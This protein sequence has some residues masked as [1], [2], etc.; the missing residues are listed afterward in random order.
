MVCNESP[1]FQ[2]A[3]SHALQR[4]A[5]PSIQGSLNFQLSTCTSHTRDSVSH[6][7]RSTEL[8]A[9]LSWLAFLPINFEV[10]T[11]S[12]CLWTLHFKKLG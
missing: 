4:L 6:R 10:K 2:Q 9:S 11:T 3:I 1:D 8:D 12:H 5:T 7:H